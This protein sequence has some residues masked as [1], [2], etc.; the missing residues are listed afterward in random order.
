M[1]SGDH[2]P[3]SIQLLRHEG[4]NGKV[5][6]GAKT[7]VI[8]SPA[9]TCIVALN[10]ADVP[11]SRRNLSPGAIAIHERRAGGGDVGAVAHGTIAVVAH[12]VKLSTVSNGTCY[13]DTHADLAKQDW[14]SCKESKQL[15]A[16]AT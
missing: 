16:R 1:T 15:L 8:K 4:L 12:A 7:A 11:V 10:A 2:G 6:T 3:R 9:I 5:M 13:H 14:R